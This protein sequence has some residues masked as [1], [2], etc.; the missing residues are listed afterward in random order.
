MPLKAR[1][2]PSGVQSLQGFVEA[3]GNSEEFSSPFKAEG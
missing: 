1:Q 3:D 2:A